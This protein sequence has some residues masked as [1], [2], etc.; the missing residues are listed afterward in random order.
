MRWI[1]LHPL[2]K[3]NERTARYYFAKYFKEGDIL[4]YDSQPGDK[5]YHATFVVSLHFDKPPVGQL[6]IPVT[7]LAEPYLKV[8]EIISLGKNFKFG[9]DDE[10]G[11]TKNRWTYFNQ[12]CFPVMTH[13][14]YKLKAI[15]E[16]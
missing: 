6:G 2:I 13:K 15:K 5:T 3:E 8:V 10:T 4:I 12:L 11:D 9:T 16:L 14:E 1:P 7:R